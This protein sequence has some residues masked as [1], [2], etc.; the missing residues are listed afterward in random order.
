MFNVTRLPN[1]MIRSCQRAVYA[2]W[3]Q[4]V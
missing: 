2:R 1:P 3:W 4:C